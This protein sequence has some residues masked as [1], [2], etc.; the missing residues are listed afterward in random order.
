PVSASL[1]LWPAARFRVQSRWLKASHALVP[2]RFQ[3]GPA[4][5]A[6]PPLHFHNS[7]AARLVPSTQHS[8]AASKFLYALRTA[9]ALAPEFLQ[10]INSE[11]VPIAQSCKIGNPPRSPPVW[12]CK[13]FV[14]SHWA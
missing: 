14:G 5:C 8:F 11:S 9:K 4:E 6:L 2:V 7:A 12:K 1:F 13:S 10:P 3:T